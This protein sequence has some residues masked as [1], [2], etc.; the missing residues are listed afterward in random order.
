M[1]R[2]LFLASIVLALLAGAF[3]AAAAAA[4]DPHEWLKGKW[5]S[6][7]GVFVVDV[8]AIDG[9]ELTG[10]AAFR[11]SASRTGQ[12]SAPLEGKLID[13]EIVRLNVHWPGYVARYELR[14]QEDGSL[15]GKVIE[16]RDAGNKILLRKQK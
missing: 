5:E 4:G 9:N 6:S 3:E 7:T 1:R 16:G 8:K 13:G 2:I 15:S 12:V 14:K 10:E 11:K